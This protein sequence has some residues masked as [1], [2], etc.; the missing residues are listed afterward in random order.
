MTFS[1]SIIYAKRHC[2][3]RLQIGSIHWVQLTMTFYQNSTFTAAND[4]LWNGIRYQKLKWIYLLLLY[5]CKA[6]YTCYLE[7][8]NKQWC[9][10]VHLIIVLNRQHILTFKKRHSYTIL[11]GFPTNGP[12][13]LGTKNFKF[14]FFFFFSLS[15]WCI[16]DSS[17]SAL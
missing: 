4:N 5:I 7:K 14:F 3:N 13:V 2:S 6:T 8:E 11:M 10:D 16:L 1:S 9:F 15:H 12:L 17:I